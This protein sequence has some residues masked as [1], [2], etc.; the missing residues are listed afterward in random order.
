MHGVFGKILGYFKTINFA[1]NIM[2]LSLI[3]YEQHKVFYEEVLKITIF[4]IT[5]FSDFPKFWNLLQS[6]Q[7]SQ[8]ACLCWTLLFFITQNEKVIWHISIFLGILSPQ[9]SQNYAIL[10][11]WQFHT[12]ILSFDFQLKVHTL[13]CKSM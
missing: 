9:P 1:E 7:S 13:V 11:T 2:F 12:M 6:Y 10:R 3:Y 5:F 4:V 8:Y